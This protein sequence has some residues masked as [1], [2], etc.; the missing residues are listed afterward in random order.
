VQRSTFGEEIE[1]EG[2]LAASRYGKADGVGW[3]ERKKRLWNSGNF[4]DVLKRFVR[5]TLKAYNPIN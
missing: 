4:S 3:F 1:V 2:V 5:K